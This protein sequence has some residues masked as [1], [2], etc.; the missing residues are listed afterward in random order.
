MFDCFINDGRKKNSKLDAFDTM[1][2]WSSIA[3]RLN[4]IPKRTANAVGKPAYPS[5]VLFKGL[6]LQRMYI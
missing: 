5:L 2:K 6:V 4:R 3:K 1:I